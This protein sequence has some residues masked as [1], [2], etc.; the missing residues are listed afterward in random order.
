MRSRPKP[1]IRMQRPGDAV[2]GT[3]KQVTVRDLLRQP[4]C[5][6]AICIDDVEPDV[7]YGVLF[8]VDQVT[9]EIGTRGRIIWTEGVDGID[10]PYGVWRLEW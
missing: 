2:V 1:K 4:S 8:Q 10:R 7:G 6:M 3:V 5:T 9:P